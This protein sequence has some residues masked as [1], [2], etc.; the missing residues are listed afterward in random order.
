M[1]FSTATE[2][3]DTIVRAT[4]LPFRTA[5]GIVGRLARGSGDPTLADADQASMD[6][7]GKKLSEMGLTE[8][9]LDEAKDP[10]KN[11]E[12]RRA[13]GGPARD[14][15]ENAIISEKDGIESD[16]KALAVLKEKQQSA[17]RELAE[18]VGHIISG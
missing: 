12:R 1:G 15:V 7:I 18:A 3:A 10:L 8:K 16:K 2:I 14:T 17:R 13:L 4:G 6:M 9:M 5:H 11:V